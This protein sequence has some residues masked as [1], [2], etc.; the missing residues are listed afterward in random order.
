VTKFPIKLPAVILLAALS[1]A[2][3]VSF[4]FL[5]EARAICKNNCFTGFIACLTWCEQHNKTN[6]SKG[7]CS[8]KCDAYWD[9]GKNSQSIGR[10]NPNT[11][12]RKVDP[13]RLKRPPTTV[14]NPNAPTQPPPQIQE[15]QH[16][17]R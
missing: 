7:I 15:R 10:P 14:S 8:A 11:P 3:L 17:S 9:S 6:K 13:G 12:P 16:R 1:F 2:F 5:T 4:G